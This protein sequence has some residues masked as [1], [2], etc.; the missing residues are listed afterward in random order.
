[1]ASVLIALCLLAGFAALVTHIT[2]MRSVARDRVASG[3]VRIVVLNNVP[4][5]SVVV[6]HNKINALL[7]TGASNLSI[8]YDNYRNINLK[9]IESNTIIKSN[10]FVSYRVQK[11]S[12]GNS[13]LHYVYARID[14]NND[15]TW[16]E[17]GLNVLKRASSVLFSYNDLLVNYRPN[18]ISGCAKS[19]ISS[20]LLIPIKVE[21][22]ASRATFDSGLG[23]PMLV[24]S[25]GR[26]IN[27]VKIPMLFA[28]GMKSVQVSRGFANIYTDYVDG[29]SIN[30]G[31]KIEYISEDSNEL[32]DYTGYQ[33]PIVFGWPILR[34]FGI[35]VN[36]NNSEICFLDRDTHSVIKNVSIL[37]NTKV[38]SKSVLSYRSR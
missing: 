24:I 15:L 31:L 14:M 30:K 25:D 32:S 22:K 4:Y 23:V 34:Y 18:G 26:P 11:I 7:D 19:N 38:S 6:H 33:T 16:N 35:Y 2:W 20:S 28:R 12:L 1:M 21:G 27:S 9:E 3:K 29:R 36:F 13:V 5:V 8:N 37:T 17:L 10:D